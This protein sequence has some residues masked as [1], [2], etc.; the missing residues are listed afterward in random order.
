MEYNTDKKLDRFSAVPDSAL[1]DLSAQTFGTS[2]A[3]EKEL[4]EAGKHT[5]NTGLESLSE[6][7][8]APTAPTESAHGFGNNAETD[9]SPG[10]FVPGSGG[11]KLGDVVTGRV[12]V[13]VVDAILPALAV[14]IAAKVGYAIEKRGLQLTASEKSTIAP[15]VQEYLS[16]I[17]VRL[18][19]PLY[20]M[21]FVVGGIY[22]GK[23]IEVMPNME[24]I[25]KGA[26]I[27]QT[28]AGVRVQPPKGE[29]DK[30]ISEVAAARKKG[31]KEAIAFLL[32]KGR[33]LQN[34]NEFILNYAQ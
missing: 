4:F 22:A 19:N 8:T 33:I 17:N 6:D 25:E 31:K 3:N 27:R 5:E 24:R 26:K 20:K 34:G 23:I 29:A 9:S 12:A 28:G 30:L 21:L 16:T 7:P 15:A 10:F 1:T 2:R 14:L 11:T 18:D 13:E 32:E